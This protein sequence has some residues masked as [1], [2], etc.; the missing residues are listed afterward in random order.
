M[1]EL[2]PYKPPESLAT[3]AAAAGA[4]GFL[5]WHFPL[6]HPLNSRLDASA[7]PNL[8]YCVPS[9][10]QFDYGFIFCKNHSA[11]SSRPMPAARAA[12]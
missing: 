6:L 3:R 10:I 9:L 5:L 8:S 7:T 11:G 1:S 12:S 4:G 2:N